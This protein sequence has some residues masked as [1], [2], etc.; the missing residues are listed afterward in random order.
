MRK[1]IQ[2]DSDG[3]DGKEKDSAPV[4]RNEKQDIEIEGTQPTAKRLVDLTLAETVELKRIVNDLY[5]K[6]PLNM[7]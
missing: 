2:I 7:S 6:A 1:F 4:R 3:E 5:R